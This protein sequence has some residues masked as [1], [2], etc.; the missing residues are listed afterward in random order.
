MICDQ[1]CRLSLLGCSRLSVFDVWFLGKQIQLSVICFGVR[2]LYIQ[3]DLE[4]NEGTTSIRMEIILRKCRL[5]SG[6]KWGVCSSNGPN[7]FWGMVS[8]GGNTASDL[9]WSETSL[10]INSLGYGCQREGCPRWRK[11]GRLSIFGSAV[12]LYSGRPG[13]WLPFKEI[14]SADFLVLRHLSWKRNL[15]FNQGMASI[16]MEQTVR[17]VAEG[18]L[19]VVWCFLYSRGSWRR[20]GVVRAGP[21]F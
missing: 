10:V 16:R 3:V 12:F 21:A 2:F 6:L 4:N 17:K 15:K 9:F 18:S 14:S 11:Y 8:V 19:F 20:I 7:D 1:C 5:S 13:P